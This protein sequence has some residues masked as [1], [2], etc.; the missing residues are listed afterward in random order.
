MIM[1]KRIGLA[2]LLVLALVGCE[3]EDN[4][5][6]GDGGGNGT[7]SGGDGSDSDAPDCDDNDHD[8]GF[9]AD[10]DGVHICI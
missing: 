6:G 10:Q 8:G 4:T 2:S 9:A 3:K 1:L 7:D 5:R